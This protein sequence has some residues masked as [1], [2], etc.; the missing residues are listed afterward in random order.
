[1]RDIYRIRR[2]S[3]S[4]LQKKLIA[5]ALTACCVVAPPAISSTDTDRLLSS[6]SQLLDEGRPEQAAFILKEAVKA[7][8]PSAL[9]HFQLGNA[10]SDLRKYSDA[11]DEYR[12]ALKIKPDLSGAVL[13]TAYA[14]VNANQFDRSMPWFKKYLYENPT[15]ENLAEVRAQLL[16]AQAAKA[17]SEHKFFD[18]KKLMETA[19]QANPNSSSMHFK[20]ANAY[21]AL[22]DN[23]SAIEEY[24]VALKINP[25]YGAAAFN[26]AGCYQN[27]GRP[28]DAIKWFQRY[29]EIEPDASDKQAVNGMISR[30]QDTVVENQVD[31]HADDYVESVRENGKFYRWPKDRL[32]LKVYIN[33]GETIAN[34]SRSYCEALKD[35][36]E[37]W[38]SASQSRLTFAF[39]SKANQ[40]DIVCDWTTSFA[41][42]R[43]QES[44]NPSALS[45]SDSHSGSDSY[46][47]VEQGVCFMRALYNKHT[48]ASSIGKATMRICILDRESKKPLNDDDMKKTC[49]HEIGHALGLRGHSSNNHDI[50][51]YSVSPTVWPVLSKRDK[52]TLLHLY[53]GYPTQRAAEA[54]PQH[55]SNASNQLTRASLE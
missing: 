38:S 47:E 52:A 25:K 34:F 5:L 23:K 39:V 3:E 17:T 19:A 21:E 31:P 41:A 32:P 30:L 7:L 12:E 16:A 43:R 53:D 29:L 40:A 28:T 33:D 42:V 1:M 18:A 4:A 14:Y 10:Y 46:P 11:I 50:M 9:V 13:N 20:L 37:Q 22:E 15:A 55:N 24:Q 26:V 54:A 48:G 2:T 44:P 49:L 8:P 6:T 35:S 45:E 51:F 27:I 36:F